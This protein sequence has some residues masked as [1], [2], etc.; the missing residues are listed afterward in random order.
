MSILDL[1]GLEATQEFGGGH[2]GGG[3]GGSTLTVATCQSVTPSNLSLA[4]CHY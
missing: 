2:D 3:G 4:L 1:Q